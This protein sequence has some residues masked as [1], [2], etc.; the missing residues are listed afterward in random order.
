FIGISF[1][2]A[3]AT[4][5]C[6]AN[7]NMHVSPA[8]NYGT[9]ARDRSGSAPTSE[10]AATRFR[11]GLCEGEDLRPDYDRLDETSLIRFLERQRLDL[12][13]ERPRADLIYI[14]VNGAGTPIPV[15]LRVAILRSA[16]EAG[17]E[18]AEAIAQHGSGAWG[19]H[20]SNLAVLGPAG[21]PTDD[22][23]FAAVTKVACWGV[24]TVAAGDEPVV[25]PGAYRE[26]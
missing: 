1:L 3:L 7:R 11:P 21:D 8:V 17:R 14:N 25:V 20:R 4:L 23:V 15:R 24:F 26:L 12:R 5:S 9:I 18:L 2:A 13:V 6:A 19:I 22:I 16:D 10:A